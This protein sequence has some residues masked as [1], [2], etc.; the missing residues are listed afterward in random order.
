MFLLNDTLYLLYFFTGKMSWCWLNMSSKCDKVLKSVRVDQWVSDQ[1]REGVPGWL[2]GAVNSLPFQN[3]YREFYLKR[4]ESHQETSHWLEADVF[5]IIIMSNR[6]CHK[7]QPLF[8]KRQALKIC[9]VHGDLPGFFFLLSH[10]RHCGKSWRARS[11]A[12]T[13]AER[14][15]ERDPCRPSAERALWSRGD[16][17]NYCW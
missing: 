10:F 12:T 9:G 1:R 7:G 6:T 17:V 16:D 11:G 2:G 13:T 8:L 5:K 3:A 15:D 14:E 4:C